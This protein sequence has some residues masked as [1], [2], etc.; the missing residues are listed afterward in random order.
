MNRTQILYFFALVLC[1]LFA[2][3][4]STF[5]KLPK[6]DKAIYG[7]LDN[8]LNYIIHPTPQQ[9]TE[10]RLVLNVGSLQERDNE[11]GYAHF[12]EHM[13]FNGSTDFPNRQAVDTLQRL[14]YRFGRD[15]NAYTTYERTVYE[16]SLLD[17]KQLDL[18]V[19]ILANFLGK[20]H[21]NLED[22]EKE[23]K[24]V[25]QEI[26]D[27]G[28]ESA[29]NLKKL[30]GSQ[31]AHRLPIS[32]EENIISLDPIKLKAFYQQWYSPSLATIIIT[33]NV[34]PTVAKEYINKHFSTLK[35]NAKLNR[36]QSERN[37]T[38]SFDKALET[39]N[40]KEANTNKLEIIR[41]T[42]ALF[43]AS[44]EEFKQQ[45]IEQLY[46]QWLNKKLS[47][48]NSQ[49][50]AHST[51]YLPSMNENAIE[52]TAKNKE[53]L[54]KRIS[55][56]A[57]V[58]NT[59]STKDIHK[60][61]LERYKQDMLTHPV[62]SE[63]VDATYLA[64]AYIDEV[65][66]NSHYISPKDRH[67]LLTEVLPEITK[68]D[69]LIKHNNTWATNSANLYL[70]TANDSLGNNTTVDELNTYWAE[71]ATQTLIF[72]K[73]KQ[74]KEQHRARGTFSWKAMHSISK[75]HTSSVI[76]EQR[77]TNIGV[78]ELTLSNG[79]RIGIKPTQ[80]TDDN[81]IL[82]VFTRNGLG[83]TPVNQR[84][85][86]QDASYFIDS[87][88]INGLTQ[89]G[90]MQVGSDREVS[91]LVSLSNEASIVNTSSRIGNAKDLFE[92]TYRKM[93]DYIEPTQDFKEYIAENTA[94]IGT[95]KQSSSLLNNPSI[96]IQHQIE[97]YKKG[98]PVL[99]E[100]L[101]TAED[102]QQLSLESFFSLYNNAYANLVDNYVL[103]SG[104]FDIEDIKA[105]AIHYFGHLQ[106]KQ[107]MNTSIDNNAFKS[108]VKEIKRVTL[109]SVDIERTDATLVFRG[110]IKPTLKESIIAQMARELFNNHFLQLSREKEGL[111]YSPSS[112]VEVSIYPNPKTAVSLFFSASLEDL[113]KLEDLAIEV[114]KTIQSK[115][116]S[117][118][119]LEQ[120]KLA[121]LNNKKLHLTESS[122]YQ[123]I[124]KLREV[125]LNFGSLSDFDRY[126]EILHSI[127]PEDVKNTAKTM[128]ST[129]SYGVFLVTPK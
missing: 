22:I 125:Q 62:P 11:K 45:I 26:K 109:N 110:N 87:A 54:A 84:K 93:Y 107:T 55:L 23:R 114:I 33:G 48:A 16:L 106:S 108:P 20:A 90:Y 43:L 79:L 97:E 116:I 101:T 119:D 117:T 29:F 7:T 74:K 120:M 78:T 14:G 68:D 127:T 3:G 124:E 98:A 44:K 65:V 41:F 28:T 95:T 111:V 58:L 83:Q 50:N 42:D 70:L 25:I 24:I 12:L 37:F 112:D 40:N 52:I 47:Q 81:F 46:K 67:L 17:D 76:K 21:L 1:P 94:S 4:Q 63:D 60:E 71:G 10:Y 8:G 92:W 85:Y 61:E 99:S 5:S 73:K 126:E 113:G 32:T 80:A 36:K 103:I 57:S 102:W 6:A 104:N 38:P 35:G 91:T 27:Y 75:D 96:L 9:K 118:A 100:E 56:V 66:V 15:I 89:D 69:V 77:Y 123:W 122:T 129:D 31:Q 59:M 121:I 128:F 30:E 72:K 19:N 18:A 64:N 2:V 88:W 53:E 115:P 51:W 34:D 82:T 49:A 105:K 86:Y 39:V 13:I